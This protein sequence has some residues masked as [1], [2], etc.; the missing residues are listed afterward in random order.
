[1]NDQQR[2]RNVATEE[3]RRNKARSFVFRLHKVKMIF[4]I[5]LA[6]G[7]LTVV[8]LRSLLS[9]PA[10]V[11]SP[12]AQSVR[13]GDDIV[14]LIQSLQGYVPSLHRNPEND[15]YRVGLFVSPADDPA[16]GRLVPIGQDLPSNDLLLAH[17]IGFDGRNVWCALNQVEGVNLKTGKLID[18]ASL[19]QANPALA[20]TWD[21]AR[22]ISCDTRLRVTT[23][24]WKQVLEVD[25]ETLKA[26][27]VPVDP[28]HTTAPLD[29]HQEAFLSAGARPSPTVWLA[30]LS[31][32]DAG[33][34]YRVKS[35]LGPINHAESIKELRRFYR[36]TLGPEL[37]RGNREILSLKTL[38]NDEYLD[39]AFLRS[40][41]DAEPIRLS[42]PDSFLMAYTASPAF[43]ATLVVA[44]V[45]T[46]G[47]II[48]KADTG[49]E[50][51]SLKQILPDA[52]F[53]AF[54]GTKPQVMDKVSE[55]LLVVIDTKSGQVSP[56]SLW[57]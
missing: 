38:S 35:W 21:D 52:H 20:E 49:L 19:Q 1:M 12:L 16:H 27:P 47:G 31:P 14:T 28:Q 18:A 8:G 32:N 5:V 9:V 6:L 55:P 50:R 10:S 15:R 53:P 43:G 23:S 25:P 46:E 2:D 11:G 22:R 17:V 51:S 24:D 42:S 3:E 29:S 45:T 48:W 44:R 54:V 33:L 57:R 36:G 4:A 30:L 26:S 39:A 56:R 41:P 34:H 13:A 7:A 37:A 40:G